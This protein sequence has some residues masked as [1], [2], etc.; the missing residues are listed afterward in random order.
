MENDIFTIVQQ[1]GATGAL[2]Y[3]NSS[4]GC[5]VNGEYL[6]GDFDRV[7]DVYTTKSAASA[8]II[9]SQFSNI[10]QTYTVLN[11]ELL[12]SSYALVTEALA[13]SLNNSPYL[14]ATLKNSTTSTQNSTSST[15]TS[16]TSPHNR[17]DAIISQAET[18]ILPATIGIVWIFACFIGL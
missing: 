5:V 8:K 14:V 12:D 15:Q 10:D 18:V 3:S 6:D 9:L 17:A 1:K 16:P 13:G 2:L 7:M 11:P 4:D